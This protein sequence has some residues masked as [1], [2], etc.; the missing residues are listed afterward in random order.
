MPYPRF[1][2]DV[3]RRAF[4]RATKLARSAAGRF[5]ACRADAAERYIAYYLASVAGNVPARPLARITG[6][7]RRVVQHALRRLEDLRDRPDVDRHLAE[8]EERFHATAH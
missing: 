1:D 4:R 3:A 6:V 5:D 8:L 7:H 2:D